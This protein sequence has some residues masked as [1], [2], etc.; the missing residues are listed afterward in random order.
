MLFNAGGAAV[1][2]GGRGWLAAART[3][4]LGTRLLLRER[5]AQGWNG[6]WIRII[7]RTNITPLLP[8]LVIKLIVTILEVYN[9]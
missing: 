8:V 2:R 5:M 1:H 3:N 7:Q 4:A 9:T 6:V